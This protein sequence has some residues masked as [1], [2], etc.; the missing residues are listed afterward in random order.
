[1]NPLDPRPSLSPQ[2]SVR[3]VTKT[4][5]Q[6]TALYLAC[7]L[8][9][10]FHLC[11]ASLWPAQL[12]SLLAQ[13]HTCYNHIAAS[14]FH[15][16]R[17]IAL[18]SHET[19]FDFQQLSSCHPPAFL[20]TVTFTCSISSSSLCDIT[21]DSFR[22]AYPTS[23]LGLFIT[24]LIYHP[25]RPAHANCPSVATRSPDSFVFASP[26]LDLAI[27]SLA[28]IPLLP[29]HVGVALPSH[30]SVSL[31]PPRAAI[32]VFCWLDVSFATVPPDESKGAGTRSFFSHQCRTFSIALQLPCRF[33]QRL[34][35][36]HR[37]EGPDSKGTRPRKLA[38]FT[39]SRTIGSGSRT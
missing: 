35:R 37:D 8:E 28:L 14:P 23:A 29:H 26:F 18:S 10:H 17:C 16:I 32:R 7:S 22:H 11:Q 31:P 38:T 13:A 9:Q 25:L 20:H 34:G 5:Q 15:H 3:R 1:M 24:I 21:S 36:L 12:A 2:R 27:K 4:P 39:A 33:A 19:R 6:P 30:S